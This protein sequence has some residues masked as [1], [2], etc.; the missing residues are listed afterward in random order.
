MSLQEGLYYLSAVPI[1]LPIAD[2]HTRLA[3]DKIGARNYIQLAN[4]AEEMR[5]Q[6]A[7][8]RGMIDVVFPDP[9]FLFEV[10]NYALRLSRKRLDPLAYYQNVQNAYNDTIQTLRT[11]EPDPVTIDFVLTY[12]DELLASS[13]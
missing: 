10:E 13:T 2:V 5:A 3:T 11:I 7:L 4:L 6:E 1:G 9:D 8:D 12:V